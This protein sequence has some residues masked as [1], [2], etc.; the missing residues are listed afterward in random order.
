MI[1]RELLVSFVIKRVRLRWFGCV[2]RVEHTVDACCTMMEIEGT[3]QKGRDT[4]GWL[5]GIVSEKTRCGAEHSVRA[6]LRVLT[7][8]N[9]TDLLT[10]VV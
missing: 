9:A 6:A 8:A 5:G 10:P 4:R 1:L 7:L 3:V 2:G